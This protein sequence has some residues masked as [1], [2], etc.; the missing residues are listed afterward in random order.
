MPI[1]IN[2]NGSALVST[3]GIYYDI[4]YSLLVKYADGGE[5]SAPFSV[6]I[7]PNVYTSDSGFDSRVFLGATPF[8]AAA[9]NNASSEEVTQPVE[10][11]VDSFVVS[12]AEAILDTVKSFAQSVSPNI[13]SVGTVASDGVTYYQIT[14]FVT[15][16]TTETTVS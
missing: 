9:L 8:N 15:P 13:V 1:L 3:Q 6:Q 14:K 11:G 4:E 12:L 16:P 7:C 2:S 10:A 5:S